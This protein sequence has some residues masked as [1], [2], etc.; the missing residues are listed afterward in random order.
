[1]RIVPAVIAALIV[2]SPAMAE[3]LLI[4]EPP[5]E[6]EAAYPGWPQKLKDSGWQP[7]ADLVR[8]AAFTSLDPLRITAECNSGFAL[9]QVVP[10]SAYDLIKVEGLPSSQ[11]KIETTYYGH[12]V[13]VDGRWVNVQDS[14]LQVRG[15]AT[16]GQ[17]HF[18]L[19]Y[20]RPGGLDFDLGAPVRAYDME[21]FYLSTTCK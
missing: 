12:V 17:Q 2:A 3:G 11:Y 9:A 15:A 4:T 1:M 18:K 16:P 8:A 21:D 5:P 20:S 19:V 14:G 13:Q 10:D 7:P 6:L